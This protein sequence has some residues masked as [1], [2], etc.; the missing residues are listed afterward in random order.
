MILYL[1]NLAYELRTIIYATQFAKS[2]FLNQG[3]NISGLRKQI[4]KEFEAD[5][6]ELYD[7]EVELLE[8]IN[9]KITEMDYEISEVA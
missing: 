5:I 9:L 8:K 3:K 4:T 1:K 6:L 2:N 7:K